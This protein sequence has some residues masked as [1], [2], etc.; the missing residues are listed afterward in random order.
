MTRIPRDS[1]VK[2]TAS[3]KEKPQEEKQGK[4]ATIR[5]SVGASGIETGG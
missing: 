4:Q 1:L 2:A 3:R 5:G